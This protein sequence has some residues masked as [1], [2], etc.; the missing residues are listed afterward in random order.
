MGCRVPYVKP[1]R[2]FEIEQFGRRL[3]AQPAPERVAQ[4]ERA[5]RY[6]H[7]RYVGKRR[8][9]MLRAGLAQKPP[10]ESDSSDFKASVA[11]D[12]SESSGRQFAR[13][14]RVASSGRRGVIAHTSS[15]KWQAKRWWRM[16]KQRQR[17]AERAWRR[18][19]RTQRSARWADER[20]RQARLTLGGQCLQRQRRCERPSHLVG[21]APA[22]DMT[23]RCPRPILARNARRQFG[24]EE[25][26]P[27]QDCDIALYGTQWSPDAVCQL[28]NIHG[29]H[30]S[31]CQVYHGEK[32]LRWAFELLEQRMY[33]GWIAERGDNRV[34]G[35]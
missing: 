9:R 3:G 8:R 4:D 6:R 10:G 31:A 26:M 25:R 33:I 1:V 11:G 16:R 20:R 5:F 34:D 35:V 14:E 2:C 32:R 29:G 17:Q 12:F 23:P 24:Q 19:A 22:R 18:A 13:S 7:A 30:C 27:F 15:F 28:L 21:D